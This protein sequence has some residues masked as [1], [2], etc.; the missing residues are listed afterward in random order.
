MAS[1]VLYQEPK[2][3]MESPSSTLNDIYDFVRSTAR[4][5][6][7]SD[8]LRQPVGILLGVNS[9]AS[10]ALQ[11]LG[12]NSIFDLAS[13]NIF[14]N[15][16]KIVAA[17]TEPQ[18]SIYR[19]GKAPADVIDAAK[20]ASIPMNKI[21]EQP[22]SFLTGVSPSEA[23]SIAAALDVE[24]IRDLSKYPPYL[25]ALRIMKYLYFPQT[26]AA[27][28][29][30][31]PTDLVPTTGQFPIERVQYSTL[32]MGEIKSSAELNDITDSTFKAPSLDTLVATGAG[33]FN[34]VA[35]GALLTF[36]QTWFAQGVALGHLLH[37]CSLA[38]GESTRIAVVD[39]SRKESGNQV[40][41]ITEQDDLVN[42]TSV[43][44]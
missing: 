44:I 1:P 41:G 10:A 16:T 35:T 31:Y 39:W 30:E 6:P 32:H 23:G 14:D 15:A 27:Y 20:V 12:I 25:A 24:T 36:S 26:E 17:A 21:Q 7:S 8:L 9:V 4:S 3:N 33:G 22:I 38:P 13:S 43:S 2:S 11:K 19:Y 40:E 28:D 34:D 5:V 18:S 29:P 37:S 42:S